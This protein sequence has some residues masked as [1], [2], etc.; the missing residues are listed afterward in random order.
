MQYAGA[1][2]VDEISSLCAQQE[3]L[4]NKKSDL[5][6]QLD[7]LKGQEHSAVSRCNLLSQ[8]ITVLEDQIAATQGVVDQYAGQIK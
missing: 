6:S 8:K 4:E 1:V 2:T 7:D 3:E 5:Q